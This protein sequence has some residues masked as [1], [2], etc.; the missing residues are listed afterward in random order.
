MVA[1]FADVGATE[2]CLTRLLAEVRSQ[3]PSLRMTFFALRSP[4][5]GIFPTW[6]CFKMSLLQSEASKEALQKIRN[7]LAAI[8]A[9]TAKIVTLQE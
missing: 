8:R 4:G 5:A 2:E 1:S 6:I 7:E 3:P 9:Q